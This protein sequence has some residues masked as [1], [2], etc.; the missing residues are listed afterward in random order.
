MPKACMWKQQARHKSIPFDNIAF[1]MV[2]WQPYEALHE[3]IEY[4][5]C[6]SY[7]ISFNIAKYYMP[8]H[9]LRQFWKLQGILKPPKWDK[10]EK[11]SLHPTNWTVELGR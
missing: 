8:D 3:I 2:T 11:V 10:R 7:L 4:F 5:I 6:R 9:M 1:D